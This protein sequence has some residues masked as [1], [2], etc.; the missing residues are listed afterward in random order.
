MAQGNLMPGCRLNFQKKPI[1]IRSKLGEL[2]DHCCVDLGHVWAY[3]QSSLDCCLGLDRIWVDFTMDQ[4]KLNL[5]II[6]VPV[7]FDLGHFWEQ[8]QCR[9]DYCWAVCVW[10]ARAGFYKFN[11]VFENA[12]SKLLDQ[13]YFQYFTKLKIVRQMHHYF[14]KTYKLCSNFSS[15]IDQKHV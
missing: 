3:F 7:S 8:F 14:L 5:G 15:C 4:V 11:T 1:T 10:I 6:W 12:F 2:H 13:T 9:L